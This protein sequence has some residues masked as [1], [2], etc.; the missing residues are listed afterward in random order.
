[1]SF[2]VLPIFLFFL[3]CLFKL[4][5][6]EPESTAQPDS[7]RKIQPPVEKESPQWTKPL[8]KLREKFGLEADQHATIVDVSE[9]RLYLVSDTQVVKTYPV[10]T[11][12]YGVGS[13]AGS[14][15]TPLGTHRIASKKGKGA[16]IGTIFKARANTGKIAKIYE[17]TT[18]LDQD[19][20]T[21]RLMW[22]EGLE[23]GVNKGK[24]IDSYR[25]YIYIH[26]TPEEG[27]IGQPRSHGCVRMKNQDIIDFFNWVSVGTLV[28]IQR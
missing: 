24:G 17:D 25:R 21:T 1:M 8:G 2:R 20:V 6:S 3:L 10:S 22:L 27:L 12:K 15:K 14:N 18:K 5:N 23:P 26:G 4:N 7:S 9:Q 11:S 16:P 19:L 13:R 28:E